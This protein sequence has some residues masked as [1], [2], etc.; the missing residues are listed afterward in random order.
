MMG[1]LWRKLRE[2]GVPKQPQA[3]WVCLR[4]R[5]PFPPVASLL[6]GKPRTSYNGP[7]LPRVWFLGGRM[8][9]WL[10]LSRTKRMPESRD[11]SV[12][13][14]NNPKR[15]GTSGHHP[16][17]VLFLF[18]VLRQASWTFYTVRHTAPPKRRGRREWGTIRREEATWLCQSLYLWICFFGMGL[19]LLF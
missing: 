12:L 13:N 4:R 17:G 5:Q 7:H 14:Q 1:L 8:T 2:P 11:F 19:L 3:T 15:T 6:P 16:A 10:S 18:R 9:H